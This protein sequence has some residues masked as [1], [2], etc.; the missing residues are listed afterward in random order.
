MIVITKMVFSSTYTDTY[1]IMV[2]YVIDFCQDYLAA[3]LKMGIFEINFLNYN[4][5][6]RIFL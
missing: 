2:Y 6:Y 1:L 4:L 5:V 3:L